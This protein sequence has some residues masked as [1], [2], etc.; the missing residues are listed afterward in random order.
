MGNR[1]KTAL[2]LA[3]LTVLF[4]L[5]G[6]AIGGTGGMVVAFV[7]AT[8]MNVGAYWFSDRIV[9]AMTGARPI[10]PNEAPELSQMVERLCARARLP[11]PALYVIADP[12]PNAFATGR[13]PAHS[14]VAVNAGLLEM[15]GR[16]EVEGVIAHELS[17]I[18]NRDTLISTVAATIAGAITMLAHLAQ[19]AAFFGG[20]SSDDRDEGGA[21]P[22]VLL[23]M[24][25][26]APIAAMIMQLAISRSREYL[27]DRTGAEISGRPLGLASALRKLEMAAGRRPTAVVPATAPLYIVNPLR[28]QSFAT[29]FSTHPPTEERIARLEAMARQGTSG[30]VAAGM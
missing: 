28:G 17:H 18:R 4:V 9:L 13:D 16:E 29:L 1:V 7:V 14:A 30:R 6:R 10:A 12:T 26:L 19:F 5:L 24:A 21:N 27:A 11:M 3:A 8:V 23:L 22:L 15:L 2:L 25:I 20:G